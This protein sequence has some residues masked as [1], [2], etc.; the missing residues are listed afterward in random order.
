MPMSYLP[1]SRESGFTFVELLIAVAVS[2]IVLG[3]ISMAFISQRKTYAVQEQ[4]TEMMQT[5]RAAMDMISREARMA[6]YDPTGSLQRHDPS[7]SDFV[8]IP[9][10][11][12]Q[13]EIIAD[14]TDDDCDGEG[15]GDTNDCHEDIAYR[16]YGSTDPDYPY[17]IKRKTGGG[18]FQPFAENI[19]GF[20]FTYLDSS[21]NTTN[22]TANIRQ[23]EITITARTSKPDPNYSPN[24]GYRTYEL[25][26]LITPK[27]LDY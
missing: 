20:T 8:G 27:N 2:G 16:F 6:G 5:A 22:I 15:D 3:A 14:I 11:T 21:G 26:S 23:V 17:Q 13:L 19:Q 7:Y 10:N 25:V 24:G 4:L 18:Y 9:Y 12:S 1:K